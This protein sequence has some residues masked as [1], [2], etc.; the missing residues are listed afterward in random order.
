MK[1]KKKEKDQLLET[2]QTKT[3]KGTKDDSLD[4]K[5]IGYMFK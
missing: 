1:G 2:N 4:N 5:R 3:C